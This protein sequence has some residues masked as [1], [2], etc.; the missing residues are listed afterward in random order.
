MSSEAKH[1]DY[2]KELV[3]AA[4]TALF[5]AIIAVCSWITVP[6]PVSFTLQTFAVFLALGV[7][8]GARGTLAIALYI[9]LGAIGLPVFSN[10]TGG[11][12]VLLG[13]TGGYIL[14]FLLSG[15]VYWLIT[16]SFRMKTRV[17]AVAFAS[18][19]F[20]CYAA[21]TAW[22]MLVYTKNTGSIGLWTALMWCVIPFIIPDALKIAL[23][24][25][26]SSRASKLKFLS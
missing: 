3:N 12:G 1:I 19:L 2:K 15:A 23:A 25:L 26:L 9:A 18:G 14:G 5:A 21:G 11:V 22:Y 16:K 6:G 20:V 13:S 17:K 8:G 24:L 10:F 4:L 7:L